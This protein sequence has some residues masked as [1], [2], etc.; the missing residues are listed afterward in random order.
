MSLEIGDRVRLKRNGRLGTV[1]GGSRYPGCYRINWD[2]NSPFSVEA[3][4]IKLL[5]K[6]VAVSSSD[7]S[8]KRE[9]SDTPQR[10]RA[11]SQGVKGPTPTDTG[12]VT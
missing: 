6:Q 9:R 3:Y 8:R 12:S 2:G 7:D 11:A 1:R 10:G 4:H 5:E